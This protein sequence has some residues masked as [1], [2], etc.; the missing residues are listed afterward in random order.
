MRI[1]R[2]AIWLIGTVC[3]FALLL[4]ACTS[5][6]RKTS[7]SGSAQADASVAG[8]TAMPAVDDHPANMDAY[9]GCYANDSYDTV[10]IEKNEDG[11]AMSVSLYRLTSL[12]EGK[13]SAS[14]AGVIF[15]TVDAAEHPMTVSFYKDGETYSLRVDESTW[16]LLEQ[17]TVI[18]GFEKTT[19]EEIASRFSSPD[20]VSDTSVSSGILPSHGEGQIGLQ[21]VVLCESLTVRQAPSASSKAVK[22]LKYGDFMVVQKQV[23]GWAECFLSDDVDAGPAGWV[24][25]EYIFI[26]PAWYRTNE[27]TPVYAWNNTTAPKV[28]LLDKNT[29]LPVLKDDGEWLIVS[30][31]GATGWIHKNK[32]ED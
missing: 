6:N 9:V 4:T 19:P 15:H 7:E 28:A 31:R 20:E 2:N 14:D 12:D 30:L 23:D 26:D 22:T 16:P 3:V 13:V 11:Y 5:K 27:K 24:N 25:T 1:K 18:G 8:S 29:T 21:A 32:A 10:F 17:E